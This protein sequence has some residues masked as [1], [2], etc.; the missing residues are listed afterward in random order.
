MIEGRIDKAISTP[1]YE[2]LANL[3]R[4]SVNSGK[5]QYGSQIPSEQEL[6]DAYQISRITVRKAIDLLVEENILYRKHGK[7]TYVYYPLYLE[8]SVAQMH[9]F[10]SLAKKQHLSMRTHILNQE[11]VQIADAELKEFSFV[12][13]SIKEYIRVCRLRSINGK[14]ALLEQDYLP[15]KYAAIVSMDLEDKSLYEVLYETA[16][17]SPSN[18]SDRFRVFPATREMADALEVPVGTSLLA[19]YQTVLDAELKIIY[20]N[21]QYINTEIDSYTI[22]SFFDDVKQVVF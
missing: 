18:F 20:Y 22:T 16:G 7:G 14:K 17:A 15:M 8:D 11:V 2:Q 19:V 13:P 12:D 3:I 6:C 4:N 5:L 1:L 10:T 21:V 9:S